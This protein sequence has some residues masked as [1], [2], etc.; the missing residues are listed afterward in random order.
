MQNKHKMSEEEVHRIA[1]VTTKTFAIVI[2]TLLA[3]LVGAALQRMVLLP[4]LAVSTSIQDKGFTK[5][6]GALDIRYTAGEVVTTNV[7]EGT[8]TVSSNGSEQTF[9]VD[10]DTKFVIWSKK[11]VIGE[12]TVGS[13]LQANVNQTQSTEDQSEQATATE[14]TA[15]PEQE[16]TRSAAALPKAPYNIKNISVTDLKQGMTVGIYT[17]KSV[18]SQKQARAAMVFATEKQMNE[19]QR[20]QETTGANNGSSTIADIVSRT[21]NTST[22]EKAVK[23]ADLV[24]TLSGNQQ[25]TVFA[26][27]DS[28]FNKMNQTQLNNLLLDENKSQLQNVLKSHV[29]Q[30]AVTSDELTDG[31]TVTTLSGEQL[32]VQIV[33]EKVYIGEAQVTQTD[34]QASNGVVHTIDSVITN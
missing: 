23:Q 8:L 6:S 20:T 14:E 22:L 29:V 26:P 9:S 33:G 31:Q 16:N 1:G 2:F 4:Q 3:V 12:Q 28:A 19:N 32:Q 25:L 18:T 27:T 34:I 15:T 13:N 10:R 24:E 21:N 5:Q 17:D 11:N 30:G 7:P